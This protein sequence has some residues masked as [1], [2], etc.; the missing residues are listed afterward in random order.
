MSRKIEKIIDKI[1]EKAKD[2]LILIP[3]NIRIGMDII[4]GVSFFIGL[5]IY[6]T[7]RCTKSG[8]W[9]NTFIGFVCFGVF[10]SCL[11]FFFAY[12]AANHKPNSKNK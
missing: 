5:V 6:P 12:R 10:M 1:A 3:K 7:I 9:N 2:D 11:F 8:I 4:M